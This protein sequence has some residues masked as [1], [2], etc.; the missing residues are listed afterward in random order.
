MCTYICQVLTEA[1]DAVCGFALLEKVVRESRVGKKKF[2]LTTPAPS[3][4]KASDD[5]LTITLQKALD[6]DEKNSALHMAHLVHGADCTALVARCIAL[7][8]GEAS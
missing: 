6:L 5:L 4:K 2:L 3:A 8:I 1:L 7:L